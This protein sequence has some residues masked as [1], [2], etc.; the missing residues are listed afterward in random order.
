MDSLWLMTAILFV[1]A[2]LTW[3]LLI[4]SHHA[5]RHERRNRARLDDEPIHVAHAQVKAERD[6]SGVSIAMSHRPCEAAKQ[7][8]NESYLK[9]Q[10]PSLPL[11][12]CDRVCTCR[13]SYHEDRR[14]KE[15]RR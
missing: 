4:G 13:Y 12:G 6:F 9:G 7:T 3:R 1:V 10:E 5:D 14:R 8:R 2:L 15:D 11:P